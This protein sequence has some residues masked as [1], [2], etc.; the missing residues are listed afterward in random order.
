[1]KVKVNIDVDLETGEYDLQVFTFNEKN[2]VD[3][4]KLA[5]I[6]QRIVKKWSEKFQN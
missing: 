3:Q 1:M 4:R 6:L 2:K 5:I